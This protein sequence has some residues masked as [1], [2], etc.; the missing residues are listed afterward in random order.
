MNNAE[1]QPSSNFL[2]RL[3]SSCWAP[4]WGVLK[5]F[6]S[7]VSLH[8]FWFSFAVVI[9]L[10]IARLGNWPEVIGS[11]LGVRPDASNQVCMTLLSAFVVGCFA[12]TIL[13]SKQVL[14]VIRT[15][16]V[17]ILTLPEVVERFSKHVSD[18]VFSRDFMAKYTGVER[19]WADATSIRTDE[20]CPA[21]TNEI[22]QTIHST[23]LEKTKQKPYYLED[24]KLNMELRIL[25]G[26]YIEIKDHVE[27][28]IRPKNADE[29][30][31]CDFASNV[32]R[33]TNNDDKTLL[34]I[35][36]L[37]VNDVDY[38]EKIYNE[39][40]DFDSTPCRWT[41]YSFE[42]TNKESYRFE[43]RAIRVRK[44]VSS[45]VAP[46]YNVVTTSLI[47]NVS[48]RVDIGEGLLVYLH[49]RGTSEKFVQIQESSKNVRRWRYEGLIMH[50]QG[51]T[52]TWSL[53]PSSERVKKM[54]HDEVIE[55]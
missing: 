45:V 5:E 35:T 54:I 48:V 53:D 17:E 27:Y 15:E 44:A 20:F 13:R 30:I 47:K 8:S 4:I 43:R 16:I 28:V 51:F 37:Q 23:Y 55:T 32:P 31:T 29:K 40:G 10:L 26:G 18:I 49:P 36:D 14:D 52:I 19:V 7:F 12:T 46:I 38:S 22:C 42:L 41:K 50:K 9:F 1:R 25:G 2:L 21:L 3:L 6:A 24:Y 34:T 33:T 39:D 11:F